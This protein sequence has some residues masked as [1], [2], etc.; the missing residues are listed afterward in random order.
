MD[1]TNMRNKEVDRI[2]DS[3]RM[4]VSLSDICMMLGGI[5]ENLT[6]S[7]RNRVWNDAIN[8]MLI[9]KWDVTPDELKEK[10]RI[11]NITYE[12]RCLDCGNSCADGTILSKNLLCNICEGALIDIKIQES[13]ANYDVD[14]Y[15]DEMCAKENIQEDKV[16][17]CCKTIMKSAL[18]KSKYQKESIICKDCEIKALDN[19]V[20]ELFDVEKQMDTLYDGL[21]G[22]PSAAFLR[23][24]GSIENFRRIT[25]SSH[26]L[27]DK[28][29][30][31]KIEKYIEKHNAL[32]LFS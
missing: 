12:E 19:P 25:R 22:Y 28:Y 20:E 8:A 5:T 7:S 14:F 2:L 27:F 3:S 17:L 13:I 30:K 11:W 29:K 1:N 24:Y 9:Y 23:N 32:Y 26:A 16:C 21:Y 6:P 10:F 31:R 18:Y 15:N 4:I